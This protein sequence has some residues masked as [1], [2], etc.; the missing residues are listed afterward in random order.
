MGIV[1]EAE[2]QS[3]PQALAESIQAAVAQFASK[4]MSASPGSAVTALLDEVSRLE[5]STVASAAAKLDS[6][7]QG[8]LLLS[9]NEAVALPEA[10][11]RGP[12]PPSVLHNLDAV[13]QA[14]ASGGVQVH[15]HALPSQ[16]QNL[17]VWV[18]FRAEVV[19]F[20]S[21]QRRSGVRRPA[22]RGLCSC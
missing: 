6:P 1:I 19:T 13:L 17:S 14:I 4:L 21:P 18:C 3:L 9:V 7:S 16:N 22:G 12:V 8:A 5:Q 2:A 20:F 15:S 10:V 11:N